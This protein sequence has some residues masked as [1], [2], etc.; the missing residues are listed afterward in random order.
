M[1][2]EGVE[3][4]RIAEMARTLGLTS[5]ANKEN[6]Y[7]AIDQTSM[8]APERRPVTLCP[9]NADFNVVNWSI[10]YGAI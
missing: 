10:C 4:Y 1:G 7:I 5:S 9:A 6:S 3:W 8:L 2:P